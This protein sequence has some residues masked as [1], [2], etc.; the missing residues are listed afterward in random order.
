VNRYYGKI[1]SYRGGFAIDPEDIRVGDKVRQKI[2]WNWGI[3]TNEFVVKSIRTAASIRWFTPE[4]S[5][6]GGMLDADNVTW[7]L[8]ER[9]EPPRVVGS[10]WRDPG[11]DVEYVLTDFVREGGGG[12][13]YVS[14]RN[15]RGG[16][17]VASRW[18]D[19]DA[20]IVARLVPLDGE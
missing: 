10:H 11:T 15:S 5:E 14:Y 7:E 18:S 4:G 17:A 20:E 16:T 1:E 12:A 13:L 3:A 9:P 2:T 19:R 6:Y 8:L